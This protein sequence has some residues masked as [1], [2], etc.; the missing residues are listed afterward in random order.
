MKNVPLG[1]IAYPIS[2]RAGSGN[3][4]PVYSVTKHNGF[5]RSDQY[6]SKQVFS[7]ELNNYKV[8]R[9]GQF[10]YATIHL[11]EGSIGIA[12]EDSLVSPMYTSFATHAHL[13]DGTYLIRFLKSPRALANYPMLGKGSAER[14]RSISFQ[15][16]AEMPV[17]L[18]A[19]DQQ[20][21]IAAILDKADELRGKRRQALA[22]LDTLTQSIFHEMFESAPAVRL[23]LR[24]A[25]LRFVSGRN[26]VGSG[27]NV[28]PRNKVLKVNAVSSGIFDKTQ[29]KPLPADYEP[30]AEHLVRVGDLI[31]TRASGT[32]DLIGVATRV[33]SVQ[34]DTYLPDKLWKAVADPSV[35][36]PTFFQFLTQSE[37]Y[38]AFVAN[39]SSGAAG[40]NNISQAKLLAFTF[41]LPPLELQQA[42]ATRVAAVERLKKTQ[43]EHLAQLDTLF[44]SLQHRAFNGEL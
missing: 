35:L 5:V 1:K 16:L 25:T 3:M 28:H 18:P 17:P 12:P 44:A 32:K 24:D 30:P 11:D 13:V 39:S 38:R 20:Q 7:R 33:G 29:H 42:F 37:R 43:R 8:V 26:L 14:R 15:R 9:E 41:D 19:I 40:V 2:E 36:N 4:F 23:S 22:H 10:A 31:V 34:P 6:F 21:R 27:A